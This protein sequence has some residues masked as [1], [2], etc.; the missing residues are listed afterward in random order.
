MLRR[1][2]TAEREKCLP[3]GDGLPSWSTLPLDAKFPMVP[4]PKGSVVFCTT[5]LCDSV[6]N[7]S[8]FRSIDVLSEMKKEHTV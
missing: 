7:L 6:S 1:A 3:A 4:N 5:K 8:I 2:K